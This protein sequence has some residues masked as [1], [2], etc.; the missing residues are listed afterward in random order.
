MAKEINASCHVGFRKK[1]HKLTGTDKMSAVSTESWRGEKFFLLSIIIGPRY[2][3]RG[4]NWMS[5]SQ[6]FDNRI[7][8]NPANPS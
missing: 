8:R 3:V 7:K 1:I 2:E 4:R 5:S 6:K